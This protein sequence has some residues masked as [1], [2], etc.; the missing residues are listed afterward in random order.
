MPPLRNPNS[1]GF[2]CKNTS[3]ANR[4][5][6]WFRELPLQ[7]R[8]HYGFRPERLPT[9][10][11]RGKHSRSCHCRREIGLRADS[12]EEKVVRDPILRKENLGFPWGLT[13]EF[14]L[15]FGE[16]FSSFYSEFLGLK[17]RKEAAILCAKLR[18][19]PTIYKQ[20]NKKRGRCPRPTL[21]WRSHKGASPLDPC[22]PPQIDVLNEENFVCL[23]KLLFY[24]F[25]RRR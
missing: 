2:R 6:E 5:K 16:I 19:N 13:N 15:F 4:N 1:F 23:G 14:W 10:I 21:Q 7:K 11:G 12:V 22:R 8:K 24:N 3:N 25:S 17:R 18:E 9:P 20:T